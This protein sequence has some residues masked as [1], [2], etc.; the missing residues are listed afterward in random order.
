MKINE[1]K[2]ISDL[3]KYVEGILNDFKYGSR[4]FD[5]TKSEICKLVLNIAV[6]EYSDKKLTLT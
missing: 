3:D 2:S 4:D 1:I 5:Q 6:R